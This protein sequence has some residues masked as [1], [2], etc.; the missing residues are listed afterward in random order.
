MNFKK[1]L[2]LSFCLYSL[3]NPLIA[4]D[5]FKWDGKNLILDNG[6]IKRSIVFNRDSGK[7]T[8]K[9]IKLNGFDYNFVKNECREFSFLAN[10][11]MFNGL[12]GW[13]IIDC[14]PASDNLQGKGMKIRLIHND[15]LEV[16]ITYLMYPGLPLI[17]KYVG[18]TNRGNQDLC[19]ESLNIEELSTR[20][21][22]TSTWIYQ[23][24]G[25]QVHIGPFEG[26]WDD[27]L[28]VFHD[29]NMLAGM[30]IGND[31]P[32][33]LKRIAYHLPEQ[34]VAGLTQPGQDFPFR[35]WLKNGETWTAPATFMALYHPFGNGTDVINT[36]VNEYVR[37]Y[38]GTRLSEIDSK[39]LF[40]YNTWNPFR[41]FVSD[42]LV[43]DV[44][45]AAADCGVQEF[46]IEIGRAHV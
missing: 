7:F 30:A 44:A 5:N 28:V 6:H 17:R 26:N 38:M 11:Q 45:K 8:T 27:A 10:G 2:I 46:I 13:E 40:V 12:S 23:K 42:S 16:A 39:P 1:L 14:T 22:A 34:V 41:T 3:L 32:G 4:Q 25:R 24:Y 37:K 19:L 31:A 36:T 18:L 9:Q 35:K 43:R 21:S 15:T 33:V 20:F 29:N